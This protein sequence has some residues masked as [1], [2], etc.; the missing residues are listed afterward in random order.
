MH[1]MIAH[2]AGSDSTDSSLVEPPA[3][4]PRATSTASPTTGLSATSSTPAA[5]GPTTEPIAAGGF[6]GLRSIFAVFT[7]VKNIF[8]KSH[9][10]GRYR[11]DIEI[12]ISPIEFH[13]NLP[14]SHGSISP[15]PSPGRAAVMC[16][17]RCRL[18]APPTTTARASFFLSVSAFQD[19]SSNRHLILNHPF[20]HARALHHLNL[21]ILVAVRRLAR[22]ICSG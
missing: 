4:P 7:S 2:C 3:P 21:S 13:T 14:V 20:R 15:T 22:L 17:S 19:A 16:G 1:H 9:Q 6:A 10:I 8:E 18:G 11:A 5:A 12:N